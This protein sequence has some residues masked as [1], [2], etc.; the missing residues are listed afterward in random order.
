MPSVPRTEQ[1]GLSADFPTPPC[2][3]RTCGYPSPPTAGGW[4]QPTH[5]HQ[6]PGLADDGI[7]EAIQDKAIH[8]LQDSDWGLSNLPHQ[9]VGSVHR[10]RGRLWVWDQL[11]QWHVIR[12]VYLTRETGGEKSQKTALEPGCC[13]GRLLAY[14]EWSDGTD[15][16]GEGPL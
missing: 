1:A 9:G 7:L 11:N 6:P 13:S 10:R 16:S 5:L 8:L 3:P 4:K 15:L 14:P 12:W 2:G